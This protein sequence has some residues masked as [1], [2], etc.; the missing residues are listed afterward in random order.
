[1]S[2]SELY[3]GLLIQSNEWRSK[4]LMRANRIAELEATLRHIRA[5]AT[6]YDV[7]VDVDDMS[8]IITMVDEGL[9]DG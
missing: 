1:M 8:G 3:K 2:G 6:C 7:E 9:K 4:A 5:Y